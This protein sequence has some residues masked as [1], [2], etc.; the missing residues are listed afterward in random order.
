MY[1]VPRQTLPG[2]WICTNDPSLSYP[3]HGRKSAQHSKIY[4]KDGEEF[5]IELYNPM[6]ENVLA[7]ISLDGKPISKSGIV[8]RA[9]QRFYL[10]CFYDD[11]KKFVFKTYEVDG[12]SS[13]TKEAIAKNGLIEVQ[14]YKEKILK[15]YEAD[16]IVQHHYHH[17]YNRPYYWNGWYNGFY[18]TNGVLTSGTGTVN[19]YY[20]GL[21]TTTGGSLNLNSTG[22]TY[23]GGT[24]TASNN[25][26]N[27][28]FTTTGT[29][30]L[31]NDSYQAN[32]DLASMNV[33]ASYTSDSAT[34]NDLT[35]DS[36]TYDNA[37]VQTSNFTSTLR[38]GNLRSKKSTME[39]GQID[40]GATSNQQF[41]TVDMD[42]EDSLLN[43]I[44]YTLLP[45]S[46]KPAEFEN[47][48]TAN[49]KKIKLDADEVEINGNVKINGTSV[50]SKLSQLL[51]LKGLLETGLI[52]QSEF[53]V[54]KRELLS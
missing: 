40:K 53:D 17:Y 21:R 5:E 2:A 29:V 31:T 54:L 24:L 9:G 19:T 28:T 37:D 47:S 18:Y 32:N 12:T 26:G 34:L 33:S 46:R 4:L 43:K 10:D 30:N 11:R 51:E 14:F 41:H 35:F 44:T 23:G 50:T 7:V 6:Q 52:N 45:E 15:K 22:T 1:K 3:N 39:T 13:E 16:A 48:F 8:V 49:A 38:S 25:A 20:S 42:F 27:T 36:L